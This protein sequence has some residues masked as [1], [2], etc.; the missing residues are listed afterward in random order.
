MELI[1]RK[2]CK[3]GPK[4]KLISLISSWGSSFRIAF[5]AVYGFGSVR[6]EGNFA[7]FTT[8]SAYGLVHFS[9]FSIRQSN[10]TSI[11]SQRKISILMEF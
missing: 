6:F 7:F 5:S 8:V 4:I 1:K 2:V 11:Y 10:Y 3:K 9:G